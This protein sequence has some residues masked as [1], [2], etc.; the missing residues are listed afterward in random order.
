LEKCFKMDKDTINEIAKNP[1]TKSNKDLIECRNLLLEE[2][3]KTKDLIIDLTRHLES[4]EQ[5]YE[6]INTEIGKRI[7]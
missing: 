4:V 7:K 6:S 3:N 1:Q 5:V 2:F